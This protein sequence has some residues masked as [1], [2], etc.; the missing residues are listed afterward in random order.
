M[1]KEVLKYIN[2]KKLVP[3]NSDLGKITVYASKSNIE[4]L[5]S[6]RNKYYDERKRENETIASYEEE[7]DKLYEE[8]ED[9]RDRISEL[10]AE[11]KDND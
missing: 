11:L 3:I 1:A 7:I 5:K 8:N 9:L 6:N 2:D 4:K 10:E